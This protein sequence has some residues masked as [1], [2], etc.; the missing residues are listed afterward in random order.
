VVTFDQD[1]GGVRSVGYR[2]GDVAYS[3]DVVNLDES[4]FAALEG[5]DVWIVDALRYRPHPTHAH[6]ERTLTWI[7]RLRPR[8]AILTNLHIDLDYET[9]KAELP[10]GVEPAFDGLRFEHELRG[11]FV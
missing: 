11:H 8:R 6:L 1:H 2:F 10:D 5:L 3:S 9:L 4:A 7:E